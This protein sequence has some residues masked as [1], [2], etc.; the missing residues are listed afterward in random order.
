MN[1]KRRKEGPAN[2]NLKLAQLAFAYKLLDPENRETLTEIQEEFARKGWVVTRATLLR[3]KRDPIFV[4]MKNKLQDNICD[5]YEGDIYRSLI[6]KS[7][8][9]SYKHQSLYFQLRGKLVQKTQIVS[10]QDLPTDPDKVQ[11]EIDKLIL[12]TTVLEQEE[13]ES[14]GT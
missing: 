8:N 6:E 3:W 14:P 5:Q 11:E 2:Q 13:G 1:P 12:E 7:K 10:P 9:G 4:A